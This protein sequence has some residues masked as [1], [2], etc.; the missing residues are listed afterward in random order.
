MP[1]YEVPGI[2]LRTPKLN[3]NNQ[4]ITWIVEFVPVVWAREGR[5]AFLQM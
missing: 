5:L 4:R 3:N 2:G 1:K